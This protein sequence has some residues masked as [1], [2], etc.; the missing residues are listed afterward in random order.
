M[1][2]RR[3]IDVSELPTYAF[4]HRALTWWATW[5][6]I[7]M[8]GTMLGVLL[9]SYFYLRVAV[10]DWPPGQTP[11]P[12]LLWGT[13]N[14]VILLAS[15]VPN[16]LAKKAAERLDL[17]GVRI[18]LIVTF[19]CAVAFAVLRVFEFRTL[20]CKWDENA[21]GSIVWLNLGFH[22]AHL[23]TDIWDSVV[24]IALMFIGPIEGKRFVDVSENS[25]YWYFVIVIWLPLYA[26]IY[27]APRWL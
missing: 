9:I 16:H 3:T 13:L 6:L 4:G 20:N 21:Y 15:C 10:P 2:A 27:L 5:S 18:W 11:P 17:R 7:L 22:T 19:A 1:S 26:V 12:D 23:L 24:L 14:T 8:E 25:I